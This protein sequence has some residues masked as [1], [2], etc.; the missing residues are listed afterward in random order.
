MTGLPQGGAVLPVDKPRGPTSHDIVARARR[1]LDTRKI[2]H[3]GTL[4]PFASGLLLLCVGSATRLSEY[5]VGM[6]KRYEA[7]V[8]LGIVT[9]TLDPEGEVVASSE[10]WRELEADEIRAALAS[11][12]GT[13]LQRPPA[14]SAKKV[15]GESAHRRARRGEDVVLEPV[16]ITVHEMA[17]LSAGPPS[18][19]D[20]RIRV[21]CSSGT[22]VRAL[23]R[24]IGEALGV[25]GYLT[26]LRR[27]SVGPFAVTRAVSLEQME[28]GELPW[29][30][31]AE[32][33]A[34]LPSV[35]VDPGGAAA[36]A[37][38]RFLPVGDGPGAVPAPDGDAVDGPVAV[39]LE[40]DLM[41]VGEFRGG[42]LRPRKVFMRPSESAAP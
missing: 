31:P 26:E 23:A 7:T 38:G 19:P 29:I 21:R 41:A 18:T 2:G 30:S 28:D 1:I 8:R 25:G 33:I 4:D 12:T 35:E 36:L 11:L 34:H 5:L 39:L 42:T 14:F 16:E 20:V 22:Y 10:G 40:G 37:N 9:D 13:G 24:D 17:L 6:D 27:L 3:T 32:A 15:R